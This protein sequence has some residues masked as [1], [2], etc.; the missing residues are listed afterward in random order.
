[1]CFT[2]YRFLQSLFWGIWVHIIQER[3]YLVVAAISV[4]GLGSSS[5]LISAPCL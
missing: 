1:L 4:H 5:P 2:I 3:K